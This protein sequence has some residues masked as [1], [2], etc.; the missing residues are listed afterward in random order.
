MSDDVEKPGQVTASDESVLELMEEPLVAPP[1]KLRRFL[2][3]PRM[4]LGFALSVM[5]TVLIV[6]LFSLHLRHNLVVVEDQTHEPEFLAYAVLCVLGYLAADAATLILLA[7]VH[8]PTARVRPLVLLSLR[9]NFVGGTTSF[10]GV[11]IPYQAFSLRRQ[12]LTLPEATSVILV[13]GVVHTSVLVLVA[14]TALIPATGSPITPLQRWF[15]VA[16]VVLTAI[17]W[18][19]GSLWV[20]RPIGVEQLP[21]RFHN[22]IHAGREA[23]TEFHH[24]G[25]RVW[26]GVVL[27]TIAYWAAMFAIIPLILIGLGWHGRPFSIITGQAVLQVIMPL[28]PL[29]GGAGVAELGYLALIGPAAAATIRVPSLILWRVATWLIPVAVGGLAFLVK[30][31]APAPAA[32]RSAG[33]TAPAEAAAPA[34]ARPAAKAVAT[35]PGAASSP[36]EKGRPT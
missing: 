32:G 16:A 21:E 24:A 28:S 19:I 15:V 22:T 5:V 12:G 14:L 23:F 26:L 27:T 11:E 1:E 36:L 30:A 10:G 9:A 4:F 8:K 31:G 3:R 2:T 18:V 29:A 33:T 17:A 6:R 34:A 25:W 35:K 7:R 13:K 20:R